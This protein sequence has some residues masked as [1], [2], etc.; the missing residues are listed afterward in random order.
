MRFFQY[1][2]RDNLDRPVQG[3]MQA[4][5]E[6]EARQSLEK[7]GLRLLT[8]AELSQPQS[9]QSAP[10]SRQTGTAAGMPQPQMR[11]PTAARTPPRT[12]SPYTYGAQPPSMKALPQNVVHTAPGSD[13][14]RFFL[15]AQLASALRAGIN[16]AQAFHEVAMRSA[17]QFRPSLDEAA[18]A[19]M[20]GK[21][22]SQV[23]ARY[24]DLYPEHVVGVVRAGEMGG[25][26]PDAL[27]EVSRQAESA[28]A[29]RRW[30]FWVWFLVINFLLSIPGMWIT[31][32]GIMDF[33]NQMNKSGGGGV[34][35]QMGTGEALGSFIG[36]LLR[37]LLW[38]WG[39]ITLAIY[40]GMVLFQRY[41]MSRV[42]KHF[43]HRVGLNIPVYGKR[44]RHENLARF[45][46]TMS[47]VSRAGVAP[48]E[49]WQL[50]ADSV[51][52]LSFR[53]ELTSMGQQIRESTKL[54]EIV[55][56]SP[57]F[58]D[59]YAPMI[60]TAEYTGDLPGALQ[61]LS[62]LSAGEFVAAQNYAK[63]RSGCWGALGCFI[64]SA[65]MIGMLLYTLDVAIP[66]QIMNETDNTP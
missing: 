18:A 56:R 26:L 24:P 32:R 1:T 29:F 22:I 42:A 21:A 48:N 61:Q 15:F 46:W 31:T 37:E 47:R 63:I 27:D 5:T 49:A 28:H 13:K 36:T 58:P 23:L 51:P 12:A 25:F 11:A 40:L 8:V 20:E 17:G 7:F 38:P 59:E 65:L 6:E 19:T 16:P 30:F 53:D 45:A 4:A 52:N 2:A 64:T 3:T 34:N 44:T 55:H 60:A 39:P 43:R 10:P 57:L 41:Y 54:S 50:A 9:R 14:Q 33:W 62:N 66:H 35:G